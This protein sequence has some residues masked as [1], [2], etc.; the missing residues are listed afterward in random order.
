MSSTRK[1]A[2]TRSGDD[3]LVS[4]E[5]TKAVFVLGA[6]AILLGVTAIWWYVKRLK[7]S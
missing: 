6:A 3:V 5:R 4:Y 2:T 1:C 7:S